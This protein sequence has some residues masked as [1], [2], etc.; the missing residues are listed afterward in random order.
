MPAGVGAIRAGRAFVELF[1][2]DSKL[3]GGLRRA[4]KKLKAFGQSIRNMG[5]KSTGLGAATLTPLLAAAWAAAQT[6]F[7]RV[8]IADELTK[9][10]PGN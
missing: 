5:L 1:A 6:C 8:G 10:T 4:Q 7:I 9:T 3:V 2:D